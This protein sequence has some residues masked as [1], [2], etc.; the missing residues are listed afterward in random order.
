[1]MNFHQA[2]R[3]LGKWID[4]LEEIASIE[5]DCEMSPEI[6]TSQLDRR[7]EVIDRIQ[8]LDGPLSEVRQFRFAHTT[9]AEAQKLDAVMAKGR[10]LSDAI[11]ASNAQLIDIAIKKRQEILRK[12]QKNTL[13]KGY[14]RTNH[15][16]KIRPPAIV[17]GN[18]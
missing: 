18:A 3:L 14:L 6:L 17:D 1:M 9:N 16:L 5:V 13:S 2:E 12:L 10:S 4:L 7:Q 8:Q 15:T 11:R